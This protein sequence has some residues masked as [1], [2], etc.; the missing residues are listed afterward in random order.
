MNRRQRDHMKFFRV[1]N[2]DNRLS[3][4][5]HIVEWRIATRRVCSEGVESGMNSGPFAAESR[6]AWAKAGE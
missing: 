6:T 1:P 4:L 3:N 5:E 2:S